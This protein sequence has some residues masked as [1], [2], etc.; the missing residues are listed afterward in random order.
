MVEGK[1][2]AAAAPVFRHRLV[3]ILLSYEV[4]DGDVDVANHFQALVFRHRLVMMFLSFEV[5]DGDVDVDVA[6]V[7]QYI[8]LQPGDDV[9]RDYEACDGDDDVV[10]VDNYDDN[11]DVD[12]L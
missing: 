9:C 8:L 4:C 1:V 2:F 3:V 11:D 6:L 10:N 5:C 7:Y 12:V